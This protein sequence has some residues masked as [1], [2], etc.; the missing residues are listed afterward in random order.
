MVPK[1]V[2][3]ASRSSGI[4]SERDDTKAGRV[5]A[6]CSATPGKASAMPLMVF[7]ALSH[8]A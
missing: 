6:I 4:T 5:E 2:D 7:K 3:N 1:A 8:M